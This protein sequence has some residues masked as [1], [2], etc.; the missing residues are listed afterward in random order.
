M[1][2]KTAHNIAMKKTMKPV[3]AYIRANAME[4]RFVA[5]FF[6][7]LE[8]KQSRDYLVTLGYH[9]EVGSTGKCWYVRW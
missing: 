9:V 5:V 2:A 1:L 8:T 4:G 3:M 7:E 6:K